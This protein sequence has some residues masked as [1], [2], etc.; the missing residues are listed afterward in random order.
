MRKTFPQVFFA[1]NNIP[2][3]RFRIFL[4]KNEIPELPED[5]T[6]VFRTNIVDR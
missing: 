5:S 2:E 6:D 3:K 4:S 1:N